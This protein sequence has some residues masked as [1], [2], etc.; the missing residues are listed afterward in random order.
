M[1]PDDLGE[2][3]LSRRKLLLRGATI[4]ATLPLANVLAACGGGSSGSSTAGGSTSAARGPLSG[5]AVFLNTPGW[6]GP[7]TIRDFEHLHPGVTITERAENYTASSGPAEQVA[8]NPSAYDFMLLDPAGIGQLDAGGFVTQ[9]DYANIP[10]YQRIIP[11]IAKEMPFGIPTDTGQVGIAYRADKVKEPIKS[12]ADFW[13]AVPKYSGQVVFV[14][15]DRDVIGNTLLYLGYD[16]NSKDPAQLDKVKQALLQL[17]PHIKA[18]KVI[19]VGDTLVSGDAVLTMGYDYETA[20]AMKR[21][22][23]I[24]WVVP[25]EGMTGYVEGWIALTNGKDK[26]G[27][28]EPFMNYQLSPGPYAAFLKVTSAPSVMKGTNPNAITQ[29]SDKTHVYKFLGADGI[30]L[31]SEVWNE[32]K[33]A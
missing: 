30:R 32:V 8:Q 25:E 24:K 2:R 4:G 21:N 5:T 31:Y 19:G 18:F 29:F 17:K 14:D 23:N 12:W 11:R 33:S 13:A 15:F 20:A 10:N 27:V 3:L 28:I 1:T 16:I 22:P 9:V 26:L 6:I 7:H